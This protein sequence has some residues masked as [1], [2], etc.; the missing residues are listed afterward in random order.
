MPLDKSL[1]LDHGMRAT[2][3]RTLCDLFEADANLKRV[4]D[5]DC[6]YVFDDRE[7][8]DA[9]FGQ[10][11]MTAARLTPSGDPAQP[12][13]NVQQSSPL[14]LKVEVCTPGPHLE[15]VLNLW[16]AFEAALFPGDSGRA[17]LFALA[18]AVQ[19]LKRPGQVTGVRLSQPAV[20]PDPSAYAEGLLYA[21]GTLTIEMTVRK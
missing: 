2:V 21:V 6:W 4:I 8:H 12:L 3:Y 10:V 17:V 5:P 20:T 1:P 11:L 7:T 9:G 14:A 19:A 15:D 18:S 16:E 13:T